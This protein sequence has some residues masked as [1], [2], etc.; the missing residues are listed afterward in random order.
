[1]CGLIVPWVSGFSVC[2][3][4]DNLYVF[5]GNLF[6]EYD[7][8]KQNLSDF[9]PPK[10]NRNILPDKSNQLLKINLSGH[11]ISSVSSPQDAGGNGTTISSLDSDNTVLVIVSD[12][13]I[14]LY[15]PVVKY[16]PPKCELGAEY[17]SC[18][19]DLQSSSDHYI[20]LVPKCAILVHL[21]CDI[22][23]RGKPDLEKLM[24]PSCRDIDPSTGRKR[25]KLGRGRGGRK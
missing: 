13:N 18:K 25:P 14:W 2:G 12:P 19:M 9:L 23:I 11:T 16:V 6:S 21:K 3:D 10:K 5:S 8:N 7:S 20:C 22:S 24:C 17:G 15:S 4:E 1:M